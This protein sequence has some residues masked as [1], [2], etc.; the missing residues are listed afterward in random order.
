MNPREEKL[1]SLA[2]S[3]GEAA[4]SYDTAKWLKYGGTELE[5]YLLDMKKAKAQ[6]LNFIEEGIPDAARRF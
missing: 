3:Y 1:L 4:R 2:R 6:L 5:G